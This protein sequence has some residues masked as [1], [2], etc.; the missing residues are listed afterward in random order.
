MPQ[1]NEN[2][3]IGQLQIPSVK[4][5]YL[6]YEGTESSVLGMGIGHFACTGGWEGNVAFAHNRSSNAVA[7]FENLKD[8]NYGDL[9][10]YT[11]VYGTRTY[12]VTSIETVSVNDTTGL[13]QDGSNK[14]TMY[15][16]KVNQPSVKLKVVATLVG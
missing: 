8:V 13:L 1:Y 14:L 16:C 7:A 11:T 6:V 2:G 3:A 10:Y 4:M 15:T 5:N 12:M 9:V